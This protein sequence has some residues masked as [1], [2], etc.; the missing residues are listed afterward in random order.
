MLVASKSPF[1]VFKVTRFK[2]VNERCADTDCCCGGQCPVKKVAVAWPR[3]FAMNEKLTGMVLLNTLSNIFLLMQGKAM[4][5]DMA[6][7]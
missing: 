5:L 3:L 1:T 6:A 2:F 7:R 4:D